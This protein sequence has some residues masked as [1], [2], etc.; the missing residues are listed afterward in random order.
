M[1][2]R[3]IATIETLLTGKGVEKQLFR[4][5][6]DGDYRIVMSNRLM[7]A[8]HNLSLM[9]KRIVAVALS[10]L[11]PY[12]AWPEDYSP[13]VSVSVGEIASVFGLKYNSLYKDIEKAAADLFGREIMMVDPSSIING[14]ARRYMQL[15][16]VSSASYDSDACQVELRLSADLVT[17]LTNLQSNFTSYHIMLSSMFSK[18]STWRLFELLFSWYEKKRH[19]GD[20]KHSL[21]I[22]LLD[23]ADAIGATDKQKKDTYELKRR[24]IL[25]PVKEL[26]EEFGWAIEWEI[27]KSLVDKKKVKQITFTYSI[28]QGFLDYRVF[29]DFVAITRG[30]QPPLEGLGE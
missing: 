23:Y 26:V 19:E 4:P 14:E 20:S 15:R 30:L 22:P 12:G 5:K 17:H 3:S 27:T 2:E 24:C 16:W 13:K 9:E 25:P 29:S 11:N 1:K 8:C 7:R 28:P 21:T 10:K 18:A 6:R